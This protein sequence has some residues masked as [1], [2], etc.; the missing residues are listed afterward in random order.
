MKITDR[1]KH[2]W[3]AFSTEEKS[4]PSISSYGV[5]SSSAQHATPKYYQP[6]MYA[7]AIFNKIALDA[8]MVTIQ[9][10]KTDPK[11]D[12]RTI[13]TSGLHNCLNVEANIDQSGVAFLHDL[14][15]SMFDEGVIA[16]VPIDTTTNTKI[17]QAF[18]IQTMRV[19]KITQWYPKHVTVRVYDERDGNSKD[20]TVPKSNTAII[21]N[22][23]Y[24]VVN[25]ENSTLQRLL[26]KMSLLDNSDLAQSTGRLDLIIS[27]PYA[28]RSEKQVED[29][30]ERISNIEKQ[31]SENRHGI[32]YTDASEKV[33]QLNRPSN[34]QL[35]EEIKDLT[36]Q[37]YNQI[38]L[39]PNVF[40]GTASEAEMR[41][42]YA[43]AIDPI[44]TF[45]INEFIRSFLTKTARSQGQ[46][47]EAY[48]DPFK[49]VPVEA[50]ATIA[51]TFKRNAVLTTNEV[52][53]IVGFKYSNEPQ[54]DLLYNPNIAE[55]N[56][57]GVG[58]G[59]RMS[60]GS[61]PIQNDVETD[62]GGS[63]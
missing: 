29:A 6:S 9:H 60:P 54:A 20:I 18:D 5:G 37:F 24:A 38:G 46:S 19:G 49:L 3:N 44:I 23:L 62:I 30:K 57:E 42:Y 55:K 53:R 48:R 61:E 14:I 28:V 32:A 45:I 1:L 2:A 7:A 17:D 10:V 41:N 56:Q 43:R 21:Q 63:V 35:H 40:N 47:L 33:T 15:Y 36:E 16:A 27:L 4:A 51:D 50:L 13:I 39:T 8:A 26:S 11:T 34:D 22:P 58:I 52:R 59:S 12:D 31:L 25:G